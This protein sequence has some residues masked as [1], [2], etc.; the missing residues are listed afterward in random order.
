MEKFCPA[1]VRKSWAIAV[2]IL[3]QRRAKPPFQVFF[4]PLV[5]IAAILF[6]YPLQ[7]QIGIREGSGG[8]QQ[9]ETILCIGDSLALNSNVDQSVRTADRG[10]LVQIDALVVKDPKTFQLISVNLGLSQP[11]ARRNLQFPTEVAITDASLIV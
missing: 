7:M 11:R 6:A 10:L 4:G 2:K 5:K 8:E 3:Q 1:A 9:Q